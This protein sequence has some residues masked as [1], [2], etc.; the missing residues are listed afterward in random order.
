MGP[1]PPA[2]L[3][4][5]AYTDIAAWSQVSPPGVIGT[6]G[7]NGLLRDVKGGGDCDQRAWGPHGGD[8]DDKK[9]WVGLVS[10]LV[11]PVS[12]GGVARCGRGG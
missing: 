1:A 3:R 4:M 7:G 10:G 11:G 12:G 8:G 5:L 2:P 6:G 9:R